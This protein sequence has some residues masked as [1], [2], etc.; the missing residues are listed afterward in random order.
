[1]ARLVAAFGSSHSIMLVS[2]REDWMHGFRAIDPK[3]PHYYDQA[4]NKTD[5]AA[6]LAAAPPGA[7]ALQ[8]PELLSE[9]YDAAQAA[10]DRLRDAIA[11]ARLDVLIVVGDDQTELFRTTNNPAIAIFHGPTI[12]NT[13]RE[14]A[15]P[16]DPWVKA[17]RMWRH[18]PEADRE[19]PVKSDLAAWLIRRLCDRDFDITAMDGLERGQF[20]GHAFQFIHRR[21]MDEPERSR[22]PVIPV[23][24]K[25]REGLGAVPRVLLN[26]G[27][28]FGLSPRALT[29][30]R[31]RCSCRTLLGRA[32]DTWRRPCRRAAT[33]A[34]TRS[35]AESSGRH[36]RRPICQVLGRRYL[37][38]RHRLLRRR[39]DDASPGACAECVALELRFS[40][41]S[42]RDRPTALVGGVHEQ[43]LYGS[44]IHA[45]RLPEAG[46]RQRLLTLHSGRRRGERHRM[47]WVVKGHSIPHP[48]AD[49]RRQPQFSLTRQPLPRLGHAEGTRGSSEPGSAGP[50]PKTAE[51]ACSPP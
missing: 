7:E 35:S 8:T 44:M 37:R 20:E 36:G 26:V 46:T 42:T 4:G 22:L 16:D 19:Y 34:R 18:E 27:R 17:A 39:S 30:S 21:L 40:G 6:L 43:R 51:Q 38:A 50:R 3:N 29:P 1:M 45:S 32:C 28:S 41:R 14:P 15:R 5:Y 9:R 48:N 33:A 47:L 23:I 24:L 11:A 10:M 25:T 12:R 2:R 13:A 49:V 31:A